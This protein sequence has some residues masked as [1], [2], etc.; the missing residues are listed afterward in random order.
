VT[1][2]QAGEPVEELA[3][4]WETYQEADHDTRQQMVRAVGGNKRGRSRPRRRARR[5]E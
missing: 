3:T 1:R 5:Q 2:G 4:W